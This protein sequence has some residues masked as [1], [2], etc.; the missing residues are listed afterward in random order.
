[1]TGTDPR[2]AAPATAAGAKSPGGLAAWW[3]ASRP[4]TLPLAAVPVLVGTALAW[5]ETGQLA[6]LPMLAALAAAL[7]IQVGTNL[8]N[9]AADF[10]RGADGPDRL[11]PQR[12]SASGWLS[13]RQ[14]LHG[15]YAAFLTAFL[16]G[17]YL[18][19]V[20][21]WPIVVIGLCSLAAGLAYTGGPRP[22]A[23]TFL[24]EAFVFL[25]FGVIAV[26]GSYYL[27]TLR[28]SPQA[29]LIG[30]ALGCFAAAVLVVNNYRD[31]EAD[32][33]ARKHTLASR[34]G[35]N[36]T[37]ALYA[38]L[39]LAPFP[40]AVSAGLGGPVWLALPAALYLAWRVARERPGP[41]FNAL[42]AR[43]SQLQLAF[44]LLL[45]V[46]LATA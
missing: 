45:G 37:K 40:L 2:H 32:R 24:G 22:I 10:A 46:G 20:G 35:P 23:Y 34:L 42:L 14:V 15:A 11:G 43:T 27:Q 39:V 12:A 38:A 8:H 36:A 21:G 25:F 33:R 30:C 13:P 4:K 26:A 28:V 16:L 44:G 9:D 3:L 31:L 18:A 6:A 29:V 7:L 17:V 5:A 1:M 41:A 19:W